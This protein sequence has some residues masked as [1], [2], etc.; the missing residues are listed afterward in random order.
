MGSSL[1]LKAAGTPLGQVSVEDILETIPLFWTA[2]RNY[3]TR[4]GC[5]GL[6]IVQEHPARAT[7]GDA[8]TKIASGRSSRIAPA[9]RRTKF[10]TTRLLKMFSLNPSLIATSKYKPESRLRS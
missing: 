5:V 4:R 2:I 3:T 10:L 8:L 6:A 7:R 1:A 9:A